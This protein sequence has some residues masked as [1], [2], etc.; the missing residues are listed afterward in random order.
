MITKE[1]AM[2][3]RHGDVLHFIGQQNCRVWY[4]KHGG[5]H[6]SIVC[7][8]VSGRCK[9]WK[10]RPTEFQLPVKYGLYQSSCVNEHNAYMFHTETDC[11]PVQ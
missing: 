11:K 4:G 7:V 2:A 10:T 9:T 5:Y 1:Q 8:R 6:E 3:L